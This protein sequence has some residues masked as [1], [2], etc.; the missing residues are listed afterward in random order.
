MLFSLDQKIQ[1]GIY[2]S[3]L[4]P[5]GPVLSIFPCFADIMEV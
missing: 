5:F 1:K 4:P 2:Q 3:F